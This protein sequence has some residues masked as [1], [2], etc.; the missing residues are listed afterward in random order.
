ME[1]RS[2]QS[3]K[4]RSSAEQAGQD[5]L[6]RQQKLS[7]VLVVED[8]LSLWPFWENVLR[9]TIPRVE[10][11]WETTERAAESL[12][13][14]RFQRNSPYDLVISDIFL[15]GHETGID[16]WNRYGEAAK[17]FIFVSGMPMSKFD[18]LMSLNYG[19]PVYLQKPLSVKQCK[20]V[21]AAVFKPTTAAPK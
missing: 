11:D 10:I 19:Y 3:E 6:P 9:S 18:S 12:L 20:D 8:D 13:K 17:N 15:E 2:F 1:N 21:V 4:D 5:V 16:L 14:H 7:K